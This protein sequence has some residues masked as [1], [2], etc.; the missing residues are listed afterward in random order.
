MPRVGGEQLPLPELCL[1]AAPL[2]ELGLD[3]AHLSIL[4]SHPVVGGGGL[5]VGHAGAPH[6]VEPIR[7]GLGCMSLA[8]PVHHDL[9]G[10]YTRCIY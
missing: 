1:P 8:G 7:G 3:P 5:V 4:L 2:A 9:A 6:D 10:K